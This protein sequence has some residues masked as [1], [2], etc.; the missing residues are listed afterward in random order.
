[1]AAAGSFRDGGGVA[2]FIF[3]EPISGVSFFLNEPIPAITT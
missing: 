1:M 3:H 2:S